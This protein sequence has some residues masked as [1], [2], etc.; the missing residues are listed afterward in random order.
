M[1]AELPW[2]VGGM[3]IW[4]FK[5]LPMKFVNFARRIAVVTLT[6]DQ[7]QDGS[8]SANGEEPAG[9]YVS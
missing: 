7:S 2:Y 5:M 3:L 4:E 6:C 8:L 9:T 1:S